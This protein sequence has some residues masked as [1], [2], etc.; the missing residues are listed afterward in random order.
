[1]TVFA[2]LA[3]RHLA[4]R[5]RPLARAVRVAADRQ[6]QLAARLIRP[7]VTPLCVTDEQVH[8]LL[9]SVSSGP[10]LHAGTAEWALN[11]QEAVLEAALRE[12]A[13]ETRAA[14]PLYRFHSCLNRGIFGVFL[15]RMRARDMI[16]FGCLIRGDGW[17]SAPRSKSGN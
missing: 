8:V 4:L 16:R 6:A 2:E 10:T 5:L 3:A 15:S 1:M 17:S 9:S 12:N 11:E 7:D 13:T 14:L